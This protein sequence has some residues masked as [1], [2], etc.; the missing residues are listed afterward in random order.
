MPTCQK[1]DKSFANGVVIDGIQHNLQRRKYCLDCSPFGAHNTR[2]IPEVIAGGRSKELCALC[3]RGRSKRSRFC[4]T[5]KVTVYRYRRKYAAVMYKGGN[6]EHCGWSGNIAAFEFH[7][8]ETDNKSFAIGSV[9]VK[10]AVILAEL[11]KCELVCSNCHRIEHSGYTDLLHH[12]AI[13]KYM[14]DMFD[15]GPG[16]HDGGAADS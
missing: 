2:P 16:Q 14:G 1:C 9:I 3:S 10:W 12:E 5:C 4:A 11:D 15:F 13:E 6:C 8:L 7:H